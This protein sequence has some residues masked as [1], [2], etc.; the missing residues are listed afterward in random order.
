MSAE[1]EEREILPLFQLGVQALSQDG[2]THL[3]NF[4]MLQISSGLLT[5]KIRYKQTLYSLINYIDWIRVC[6]VRFYVL[7]M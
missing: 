4:I 7:L 3:A 5:N 2:Y 1:L 6:N